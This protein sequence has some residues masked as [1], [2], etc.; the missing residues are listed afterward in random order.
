MGTTTHGAQGAPASTPTTATTATPTT[1]TPVAPSK[2]ST[3]PLPAWAQHSNPAV[4]KALAAVARGH[5]A[6]YNSAAALCNALGVHGKANQR[7][8]RQVLRNAGMG[9]GRGRTYTGPVGRKLAQAGRKVHAQQAKAAKAASKAS[10][11]APAA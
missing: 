1:A 7:Q 5:G 4:A 3:A 10:K 9:V 6:H 2:A 11:G 8:V